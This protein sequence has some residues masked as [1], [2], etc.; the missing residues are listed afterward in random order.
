MAVH[1]E[2]GAGFLERVYHEALEIELEDRKIPYATNVN[3]TVRYRGRALS[4]QYRVD[5]MC[6]PDGE[7]I[8]LELKAVSDITRAH[9]AQVIHYMKATGI[10]RG[11][12]VNFGAASLQYERMVLGWGG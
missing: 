5:L 2:L 9:R 3:V 1:R 10:Q 7:P 11:L 12:L 4:C 8:L 6:F